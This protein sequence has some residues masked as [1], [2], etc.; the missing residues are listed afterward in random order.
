M[1]RTPS[2]RSRIHGCLLGLATA[3][4]VALRHRGAAR[5]GADDGVLRLGAD[6]QLALYTADALVQVLEWANEGVYADQAATLW[7]AGLRWAAVQGVELPSSAPPA[8]PRWIDTEPSVARPLPVRP[9]WL[10]SLASGEMGTAARPLGPEF[11]D[12]A[13]AA[14]TAPLGLVPGTPSSAVLTMAVD[15]ASLTHGHPDAVQASIALAQAV[16]A[17]LAGSPLGGAVDAARG[18]IAGL[19]SPEQDIVDALTGNSSEKLRPEAGQAALSLAEGVRAALSAGQEGDAGVFEKSVVRASEAGPDAAAITGAL[20]GTAWG[21]E[22]VPA[23]WSARL[24][25]A[26]VVARLAAMLADAAGAFD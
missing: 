19:R 9:A 16:H 8:P 18:A 5:D 13:A 25:G 4:A 26:H 21:H 12:A 3:E 20:L 1:T 7:L 2:T 11:D 10:A 15:G 24:E 22:A 6:G 14:R 23:E 17:A